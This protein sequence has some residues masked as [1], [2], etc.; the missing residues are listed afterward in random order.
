M[1]LLTQHQVAAMVEA[2]SNNPQVVNGLDSVTAALRRVIEQIVVAQVARECGSDHLKV[3]F[4]DQL[5]RRLVNEI[6]NRLRA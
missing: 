4:A 6:A 5:T 1:E 3:A 2:T